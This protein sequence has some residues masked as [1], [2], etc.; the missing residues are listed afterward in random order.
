MKKKKSKKQE[1]IIK[2]AG[3]IIENFEPN[4]FELE[5]EPENIEPYTQEKLTGIKKANSDMTL[6]V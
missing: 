1:Q 3:V 5:L 6:N 4:F 2:E